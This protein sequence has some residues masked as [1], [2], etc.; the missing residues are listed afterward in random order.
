MK[1]RGLAAMVV[2]VLVAFHLTPAQAQNDGVPCDNFIRNPDGS[3]TATSNLRFPPNINLRQGSVMR[4][5]F[6][7]LGTD[8]AATL[9]KSCA[10]VPVQTPQAELK[11]LADD[12]GVIDMQTLTCGQLLTVYQEDVD[13]LMA[14]YSGW[15]NGLAKNHTLKVQ[16]VKDGTHNVIVYCKANP[17]KRIVEAI[18]ALR[19]EAR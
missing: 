10:S 1:L 12:K 13:F 14:W 16:A 3:W 11:T 17:S 19:G 18:E 7:I 6:V 9:A 15:S 5:G 8:V 4:P 2:A